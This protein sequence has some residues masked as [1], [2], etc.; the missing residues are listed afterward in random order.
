[1]SESAPPTPDLAPKRVSV[2][3]AALGRWAEAFMSGRERRRPEALPEP[4]P[5]LRRCPLCR[6]NTMALW[7]ADGETYF[8][9]GKCGYEL[10]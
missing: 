2:D 1:M 4:P 5:E 9:C 6:F 8:K 10:R 3:W 7:K